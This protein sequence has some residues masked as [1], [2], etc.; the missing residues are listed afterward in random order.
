MSQTLYDYD[1]AD[2]LD[3]PEA[4]EVFMADAVESGDAAYIAHAL[5]VIA[6]ARGMASIAKE[7]GLSRE[8]LYRSLSAQGNPTLD[9]LVRV[10]AAL[11]LKM[12]LKIEG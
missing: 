12:R 11:G 3:T 10:M 7:T 4:I 9:T 8:Q 2:S 5:G 6:K 1:P